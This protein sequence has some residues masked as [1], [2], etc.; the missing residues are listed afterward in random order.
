MTGIRL[1]CLLKSSRI[2]KSFGFSR[3]LLRNHGISYTTP[4][5][6]LR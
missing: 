5:L 2:W 6:T 3:G 1:R 4:T